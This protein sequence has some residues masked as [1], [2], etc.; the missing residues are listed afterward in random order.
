MPGNLKEAILIPLLKKACL[1][2]EIFNH[3]GLISN[4]TYLSKL[5]EKVVATWLLGHMTTNGPHECFQSSYKKC[6]RTETAHDDILRAVDENQCVT[7]LLLDL[8][9]AFDTIDRDMLL[10]RL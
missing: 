7:L 6:H 2:P 1:G 4:L 3:F 9:A 10:S 8:S 5:T